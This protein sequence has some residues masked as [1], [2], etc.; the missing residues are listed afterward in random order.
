MG[1]PCR[2]G[3]AVQVRMVSDHERRGVT[4]MRTVRQI[5]MSILRRDLNCSLNAQLEVAGGSFGHFI[6]CAR[7]K[8]RIGTRSG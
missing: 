4:M 2:L 6:L 5:D 3:E 1:S 7:W 8:L